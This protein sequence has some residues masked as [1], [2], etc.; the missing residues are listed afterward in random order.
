[1]AAGMTW[2]Y[3]A[4]QPTTDNLTA[5]LTAGANV[6]NDA[7]YSG[8]PG[9][10][11]DGPGGSVRT[12]RFL[13]GR[14][15]GF[16]TDVT[17][18]SSQFGA[19]AWDGTTYQINVT[20]LGGGGVVVGKIYINPNGAGNAEVNYFA[21]GTTQNCFLNNCGTL[22]GTITATPGVVYLAWSVTWSDGFVDTFNFTIP[23]SSGGGGTGG[24]GGGTLAQ[25]T[26]QTPQPPLGVTRAHGSYYEQARR[27]RVYT[28]SSASTGIAL[29]APAAGGGHPTLWNPSDSGRYVSLIRL[30]LGYVSGNNAPTCLEW[31][32]TTFTGAAIATGAPIL[33]FVAVNPTGMVG[34]GIDNRARWSPTTNTFTAAPVFY[35]STGLSL[36]TGISSTAVAP[37]RYAATYRGDLVLAPGSAIS[38]CTKGTTT[39]ALFQVSVTWEEATVP[40]ET[41]H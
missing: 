10:I 40:P 39:T 25:I 31:A 35:R 4:P 9:S 1:M 41:M 19:S 22:L 11:I 6:V 32:V 18:L 5:T 2:L 14:D 33:T 29:I 28:G 30:E 13:Y 17:A 34:A 15:G 23:G 38:L 12:V 27:R 21:N 16:P 36:F 24:G 3:T 37:W 26:G 8:N 20:L 7:P